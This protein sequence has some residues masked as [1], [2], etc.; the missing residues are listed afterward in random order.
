MKE[1]RWAC[2]VADFENGQD[3]AEICLGPASSRTNPSLNALWGH[4]S[5]I[6]GNNT[7]NVRDSV[8]APLLRIKQAG[9]NS[10]LTRQCD[11][12]LMISNSRTKSGEIVCRKVKHGVAL[13][14]GLQ[15]AILLSASHLRKCK[16]SSG[17]D[18]FL[19]VLCPAKSTWN[20]G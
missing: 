14:S 10:A 6:N 5:G 16:G 15:C 8:V 20:M 13:T 12:S 2:R 18:L 7:R 1:L 11:H 3:V 9:I 19:L 4:L 17:T